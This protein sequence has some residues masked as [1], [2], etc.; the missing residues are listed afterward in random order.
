MWIDEGRAAA[1]VWRSQVVS[2]FP[3]EFRKARGEVGDGCLEATAW[4]CKCL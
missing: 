2:M 1:V 4:G 3:Y